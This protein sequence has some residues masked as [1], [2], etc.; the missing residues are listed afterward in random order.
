[1]HPNPPN[2]DLLH[3]IIYD[4]LKKKRLSNSAEA[5]RIETQLNGQ[6][7]NAMDQPPHGFLYNFWNSL[8]EP[9]FR[10]GVAKALTQGLVVNIDAIIDGLPRIHREGYSITHLSSFESG[11]TLLSCDIS[12]DGN[13]VASGGIGLKPFICYV[14]TPLSVTSVESHSSTI[15]DVRFQPG[16]NIFATASAD[17]T[18]KLWDANKPAIAL[19]KFVGHNWR[20]RSLDFHPLGR[21]L[22]SSD[23]EGVIKAWDVNR[24][25]LINSH[26]VGGSR[27]RF[28]PGYGS[29]LA[30]ANRNVITILDPKNFMVINRLEGHVND[31]ESLCWDVS[32][33]MIASVSEDSVRVWS[34]F[35]TG[36]CIYLYS[37]NKG[38]FNS[39]IFHPRYNDV[40][41][42]GGSECLEVLILEKTKIS[43]ARASNLSVTGLAATTAKSEYIASVSQQS[44]S[45]VNIWK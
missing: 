8:H 17:T 9:R 7:P 21:I 44:D 33:R 6:L 36:P 40:L 39:I 32:G 5:F 22:C 31:I 30:V 35:K 16:T 26:T 4:Y 12:S 24:Q 15:L 10:D 27:V 2:E 25:L 34:L 14:G 20:V 45:V 29:L 43:V 18:V 1:M 11:Q 38:R 3:I 37:L 28:Q 41:V 13:T 23:A 19:S 42:I